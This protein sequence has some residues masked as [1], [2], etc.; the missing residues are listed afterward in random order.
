MS[1]LGF[2]IDFGAPGRPNS[3][4]AA[5]P[6]GAGAL[7]GREAEPLTR[8]AKCHPQDQKTQCMPP[9]TEPSPVVSRRYEAL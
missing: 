4:A 5:K 1:R 3:A 2:L 9:W 7:F 8:E 6:F